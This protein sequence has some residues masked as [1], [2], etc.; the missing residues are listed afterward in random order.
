M[1]MD[2]N[3]K[4]VLVAGGTGALG[5]AVSS[6]FVSAGAR[7]VVTYRRQKEF[8]YLKGSG[9]VVDGYRVDLSDA[10]GVERFIA[11]VCAK[12]GVPH[13]LVNT[14]G[15]YAGGANSWEAPVDTLERM[16]S[17][18]LVPAYTLARAAAPVM[19]KQGRGSIVNVAAKS[20][21]D[22]PAGAAAYA[23]SKAAAI[24]LFGS[25]A[26]ELKGSGVRVNSIV[27]TIIDTPDNRAAMPDADFSKWMPTEEIS[28]VIMFLCSDA[29]RA[30]HGAA[31][32]V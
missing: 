22:H 18:N 27:P 32:P 1:S 12:H 14:V 23:A 26:A 17:M 16:L 9:T 2:F 30:V 28:R 25:L 6:A 11:E 19:L 10:Y 5:R 8:D 7:V 21:F 20:A 13:A 29:S 31:I 24:A 3:G 4:V 15:G